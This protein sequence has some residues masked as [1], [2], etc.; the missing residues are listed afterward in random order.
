MKDVL[1]TLYG[2]GAVRYIVELDERGTLLS[3]TL[4]DTGDAGGKGNTRGMRRPV[5]QIQRAVGITP[6]LL[7]DNAEY[8]F[9]LARE[10]AKPTR[11]AA[12]HD[13][14]MEILARCA[15]RTAE[16]GVI[17]VQHFLQN[18]PTAKLALADD[19][20]RG[21]IL[22]FSVNGV[23]P[24]DLPPVQAFWAHEH[25]PG[26]D[27]EGPA[28][29]MQCLICGEEKPVLARLQAKIKGV[30]GGQTS[31]TSLISA[32]AN[33][34]ESYGLE[35]SLIAPTCAECGERFTRAVNDLLKGE[36]SRLIIGGAAFVFWTR[37]PEADFSFWDMLSK[38][39][40]GQVQTLLRS[41][42]AGT[43]VGNLDV[44]A[45]YGVAL[46]GSG[47]RVVVRDWIDTTVGEAKRH[48]ANWFDRQRIVE[49]DG[50]EGR[51][52]GLTALAGGTVREL[53]DLSPQ[54]PRQ[55][56]RSALTGTP[57][58]PG[59]LY[60]AVRRNRAEQAVTRQRAALI[61]LVL[62]SREKA[63]VDG[64]VSLDQENPSE[65]YRCGRL[66]A[67]LEEVQRLAVPGI[68]ATIGSR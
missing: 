16:P 58:P 42:R 24:V 1:P 64:M 23:F 4:T 41:V 38:P 61:K 33:A 37:E 52:Y 15:V 8:T 34:F 21:A 19:F 35:N 51:P 56:L 49:S 66:F 3:A 65:A 36:H 20:D 48:L 47:G 53:R 40:A 31:G 46:S 25:N 22:T 11:V 5:P 43:G 39:E 59:L 50:S 62:R 60:Q 6:L 54:T 44:T 55:L 63:E 67:V 12:C 9:G 30:P 29:L 28:P 18:D 68:K 17:A 7:A 2:Q 32:N 27:E 14:Y 57:L 13:A 26:E 45:F 10:N